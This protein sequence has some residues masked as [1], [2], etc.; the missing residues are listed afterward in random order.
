M[1]KDTDLLTLLDKI[2]PNKN[3]TLGKVYSDP[4]A[5][6]FRSID[7]DSAITKVNTY[8]IKIPSNIIQCIQVIYDSLQTIDSKLHLLIKYNDTIHDIIDTDYR[9]SPL[10][11]ALYIA[12]VY[13]EFGNNVNVNEDCIYR[14][15]KFGQLLS[16]SNK[17]FYIDQYTAIT[18]ITNFLKL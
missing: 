3:I 7:E 15:N 1:N 2:L 10:I 9:R 4:Y 12:S 14:F 8:Y 16:V 17:I 5:Y 18:Y 11:S 6:A 13:S